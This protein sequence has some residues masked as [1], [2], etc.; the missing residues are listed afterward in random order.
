MNT[1]QKDT[2]QEL[3]RSTFIKTESLSIFNKLIKNN[4]KLIPFNVKLNDTGETKYFPPFSKEW[5]NSI[6]VFNLNNLKNLP[7]Y[8]ININALIKNYF[9]LYFNNKFINNKYISSR[10]KHLSLNKIFV[11]K[12]EIKHTNSKATITIYTYNR[13]KLVLL[14]KI[15]FIKKLFFKKILSLLYNGDKLCRINNN[16]TSTGSDMIAITTQ[17]ILPIKTILTLLHKELILFRRFKLKLSL[18]KYK[19]EEKFLYKL[20]KLISNFYNKKVEFNIINMKS[21]ILTSDFFTKI[22]SLKLQNRNAKVMRLINIILNKVKFPEVN[23]IRE[24][25]LAIKSVNMEL[26]NNKYKNINLNSILTD[27]I[28]DDQN[29]V[30]KKTIKEYKLD[31]IFNNLYFNLRP[32]LS[33]STT[34]N[35]LNTINISDINKSTTCDNVSEKLSDIIFNNIKYKNM[36]GIRLEIKGR[37]T[38]RYRADRA[39][40]KVKWK[41]GLKNIDSSY[42]G[43]SSVN[44]RGFIK[45]NVEYTICTSK[46]RIGAFAVKGWFG[47]K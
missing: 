32:V 31:N 33:S 3:N 27:H 7:L 21:V 17:S 8:N 29:I 25:S 9:N 16:K 4:S 1:Q 19:F 42:K 10:V 37:L 44:L 38:K 13:E 46:R 40:F 26:I 36:G 35:T 2:N 30:N 34:E 20:S 47:G 15:K 22:L 23:K 41:G 39:L 6:Y 43:L 28:E 12:A 14:K 11:S 24:K 18:N 45:P 5:K